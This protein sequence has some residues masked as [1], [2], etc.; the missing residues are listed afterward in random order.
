MVLTHVVRPPLFSSLLLARSRS[1]TTDLAFSF[2]FSLAWGLVWPRQD[3]IEKLLQS[4]PF[5]F[6]LL[7][8]APPSPFRYQLLTGNAPPRSRWE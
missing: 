6:A 8:S 3:L 4:V 5:L 2:F 1:K 7:R